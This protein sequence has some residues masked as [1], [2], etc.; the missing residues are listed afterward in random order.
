MDGNT[1][2]EFRPLS[3]TS[4][5]F[6]LMEIVIKQRIEQ[7]TGKDIKKISDTQHGFR[8]GLGTET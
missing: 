3:A 6:K 1:I 7:F 4:L 5:F 2:D 8:K